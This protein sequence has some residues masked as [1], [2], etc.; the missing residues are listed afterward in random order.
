MF[1]IIPAID[2]LEGQVV[3]LE[4]GDYSKKT[5]YA[6]NPAQVAK[7]FEARGARRLHVVDLEGALKGLPLNLSIIRNLVKSVKIPIQVGGGIRDLETIKAL[8]DLGVERV[9]LGTSAVA[10]KDLIKQACVQFGERIIVS[11]DVKEGLAQVEGWTKETRRYAS[12]LAKEMV[13]LGI[14]HFIYTDISRDGMLSGPNLKAIEEFARAVA[15]PVIASGGISSLK[16]IEELKKIAHLEGC[17]I[18]K[19]I[20]SGK[21]NLKNLF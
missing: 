19:A 13:S 3:R 15:V 8:L 2:I 6:D 17:I 14:K 5:V 4:R 11:I 18:G 7:D 1:E 16:D 10:N 21:I 9:I 12:D 20:Y